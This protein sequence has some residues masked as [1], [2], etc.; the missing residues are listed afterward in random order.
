[1]PQTHQ[2]RPS[3]K[4]TPTGGVPP[5]LDQQAGG[6][7]AQLRGVGFDQGASQLAPP[8]QAKGKG[9]G[10]GPKKTPPKSKGGQSTKGGQQVQAPRQLN[11]KKGTA[12][13]LGQVDSLGSAITAIGGLMDA[14]APTPGEGFEGDVE[15]E[16]KPP[17]SLGFYM[18]LGLKG[19]VKRLE[20][21]RLEV[22]GGVEVVVGV[23]GSAEI[24]TGWF[25]KYG[26]S[27]HAG[28]KGAIGLKATGDN[29]AHCMRLF[30]LGVHDWVRALPGG[31]YVASKLFG[32]TYEDDTI[33]SMKPEGH[34]KE[35]SLE[36][37]GEVGLDV[38]AGLEAGE[39][40]KAEVGAGASVVKT[41][42]V[43]KGKDGKRKDESETAKV[44]SI[45]LGGETEGFAAKGAAEISFKGNEAPDVELDIEL[46]PKGIIGKGAGFIAKSL[47]DLIKPFLAYCN[48]TRAQHR[49]SP[50]TGDRLAKG[51]ALWIPSQLIA[52]KI[53][54]TGSLKA[55]YNL[56]LEY[57]EGKFKAWNLA[58]TRAVEQETEVLG[59]SL[60]IGGKTTRDLAGGEGKG[61][62]K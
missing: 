5:V 33:K 8:V 22:E 4:S 56:K 50:E 28:V 36:Y 9:G 38:G 25:G 53:H 16:I 20:D 7:K 15:V 42:K 46:E 62:G 1:M 44:L 48:T 13:K 10:Q 51:I 32:D 60:K 52:G 54:E 57:E 47:T 6:L 34:A 55:G 59:S 11:I 2:Q 3:G 29:G 24:D 40:T 39:E 58:L 17:E 43:T 45:E 41:N 37:S 31:G 35:S 61:G 49:A 23:A 26:G 18:K 19:G 12:Q 14:M 27:W 21:G 30:G